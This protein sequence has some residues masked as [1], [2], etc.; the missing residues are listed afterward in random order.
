VASTPRSVAA[1]VLLSPSAWPMGWR[2]RVR[3]TAIQCWA[4]FGMVLRE[5]NSA[6]HPRRTT[7]AEAHAL[8]LAIRVFRSAF[9]SSVMGPA[10]PAPLLRSCHPR[11]FIWAFVT[12]N[13]A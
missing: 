7:S 6:S 5:R 4:S 3:A 8:L 1:R 11:A 12:K 2:W 13:S 10:A 9:C